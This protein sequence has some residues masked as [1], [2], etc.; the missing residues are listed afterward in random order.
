[1]K[2]IILDLDGGL[3][4]HVVFAEERA[5]GGKPHPDAFREVLRRVNLPADHCVM[6]GDNPECD[7]RGGRDA[8]LWTIG[9]RRPGSPAEHA[10]ADIVVGTLADVPAAAEVLIQNVGAHAA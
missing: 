7:T 2:A 6:V 3:V 5:D 10:A 9:I 1:M 8:G 4:D